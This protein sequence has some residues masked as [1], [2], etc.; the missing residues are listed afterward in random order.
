MDDKFILF[1]NVYLFFKES[2]SL[3][4]GGAEEEGDRGSEAGSKLT[5]DSLM[6]GSNSQA[7]RS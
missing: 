2:V 3:S 1:F 6:W 7:V 4:G 5:A